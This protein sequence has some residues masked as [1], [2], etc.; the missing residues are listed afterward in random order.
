[1]KEYGKMWLAF[2]LNLSFSLLEAVG[3]L[4]TGSVAILS[5][6]LHDLVRRGILK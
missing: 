1:M 6:A 3:G 2:L 4:L 5:D